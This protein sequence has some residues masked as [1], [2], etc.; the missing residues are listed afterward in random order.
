MSKSQK[1]ERLVRSRDAERFLDLALTDPENQAGHLQS[2]L[3]V[4][5]AGNINESRGSHFGR[6]KGTEEAKDAA[7]L[8]YMA[9]LEAKTGETRPHTLARLADE[10]GLIYRRR[11]TR[12]KSA[13]ARVADR[14]KKR[15]R[16]QKN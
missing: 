6:P 12:P 3:L 2:A 10:A 5:W 1:K 7:A 13:P 9:A 14:Y 15:K 11:N 4:R 8:E 16:I